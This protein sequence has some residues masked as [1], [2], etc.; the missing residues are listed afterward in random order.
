MWKLAA[1]ALIVFVPAIAR[2]DS[3]NQLSD[4]ADWGARPRIT[5]LFGVATPTGELGVEY[6]HMI[7]S[8]LE[9]GAAVGGGIT[10]AQASIMP[11]LRTGAGST[12]VTFGT[13]LSGGAYNEFQ[14]FQFCLSTGPDACHDNQVRTTA[15]WANVEAGLQ[16]TSRAGMTF[17]LYGGA[18]RVIGRG[19]CHNGDCARIDNMTLPYV[20]LALGHT[21]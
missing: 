4:G 3:P 5:A 15:L 2:A 11:R 6:T 10:G 12:S 16:V 17:R 19:A 13:G 7:F 14:L 8:H 18:G 21:L 1:L 20:G 9:I